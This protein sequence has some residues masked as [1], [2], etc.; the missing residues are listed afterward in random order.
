MSSHYR[1]KALQSNAFRFHPNVTVMFHHLAG[2]VASDAQDRGLD[3]ARLKQFRYALMSQIVEPESFQS[4]SPCEIDL[5]PDDALNVVRHA[6]EVLDQITSE[7]F[8]E[9]VGYSDCYQNR[10]GH[11]SRIAE[12]RAAA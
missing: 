3:C 5:L 6:E 2:H 11:A 7:R 10:W 9:V 4:S 12:P 1:R 8:F